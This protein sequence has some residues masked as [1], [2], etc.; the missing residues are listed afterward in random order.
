MGHGC[1][2]VQATGVLPLIWSVPAKTIIAF[3]GWC[4]VVGNGTFGEVDAFTSRFLVPLLS[5]CFIETGSR[6]AQVGLEL[7]TLLHLPP[8]AGMTD[9]CHIWTR[10]AGF[11][12]LQSGPPLCLS[13][14]TAA[15]HCSHAHM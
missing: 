7:L 12:L 8:S 6:V 10:P 9:V 2:R 13:F 14:S 4:M 15:H 11:V 1:L 5:V 3:C